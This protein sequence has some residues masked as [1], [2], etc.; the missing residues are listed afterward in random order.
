MAGSM[1]GDLAQRFN[2]SRESISKLEAYVAL[3]LQWQER[4]NLVAPST[5]AQVWERHIADSLQVLPHMSEA[6]TSISDLGSGAG[7]PGLVLG[8][9][10]DVTVHL[11][12]S[13]NKK[14]AFLR[15]VARVAGVRA[16]VHTI[17]LEEL[18]KAG[19]LPVVSIV[20]ARA[21]A[22]LPL[23]LDYAEPF[24]RR[25]ATGLFHKGRELD[26]EL[27]EAQKYWRIDFKKHK[28]LI[29][30]DSFLLEVVE[31]KRAI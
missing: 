24:L 11:Y 5:V 3:L 7:F 29:D 22:P 9:V 27:T 8:C 28:G 14:S 13:N 1:P 2:V 12:E 26:Q 25:G 18:A 20:T 17:R 30:S 15:E 4:I 31:A 6:V 19:E 10:R 23:L 16:Q 21:L